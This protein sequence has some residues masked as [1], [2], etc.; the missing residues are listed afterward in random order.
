MVDKQSQRE[1]EES[2]RRMELIYN[3]SVVVEKQ[4]I[5]CKLAC[6]FGFSAYGAYHAFRFSEL[7][8]H[9]RFGDKVFNVFATTF[10]FGLAAA[11]FY[12]AYE[13]KMGKDLNIVE[14]R[15]SYTQRFKEAYYIMNLKPS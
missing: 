7:W 9:Y 13:I 10:I 1:H 6:G 3:K 2:L 11:N 12:A 8:R 15:P 4:C 14:L 5:G